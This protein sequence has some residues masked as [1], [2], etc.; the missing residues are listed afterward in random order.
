G[1]QIVA[2]REG[3][4]ERL[5]RFGFGL[6]LLLEVLALHRI[7]HA[8]QSRALTELR[9]RDVGDDLCVRARLGRRARLEAVVRLR[10]FLGSLREVRLERGV[11]ALQA[12][13]DADFL[14]LRLSAAGSASARRRLS[15]HGGP[16][17]QTRDRHG[18]D[19]TFHLNLLHQLSALGSIS[20]Q[21]RLSAVSYAMWLRTKS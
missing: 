5:G 16:D 11:A 4:G 10:H 8:L 9:L 7:R 2:E 15:E 17:E 6:Q 1:E 13:R 18:S 12:G 19:D 3:I 14:T 21:P 20:C